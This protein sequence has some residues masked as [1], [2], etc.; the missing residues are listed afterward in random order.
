[1]GQLLLYKIFLIV[2]SKFF[3]SLYLNKIGESKCFDQYRFPR[4]IETDQKLWIIS[5]STVYG[6]TEE[7]QPGA[8]SHQD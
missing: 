5:L 8:N 3:I 4:S 1:M 7:V 6:E 2:N